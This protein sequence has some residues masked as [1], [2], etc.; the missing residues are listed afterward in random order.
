MV[1]CMP[2]KTPTVFQLLIKIFSPEK[3]FM[4]SKTRIVFQLLIKTFSPDL[5]CDIGSM[6][7]TDVFPQIW[8]LSVEV[9]QQHNRE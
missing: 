3:I 9:R 7:G 4:S 2:N 8:D 6:D 1:I 5:I